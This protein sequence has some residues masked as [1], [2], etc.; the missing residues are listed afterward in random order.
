MGHRYGGLRL[1]MILVG[2]LAAVLTLGSGQ[3]GAQEP[4]P[5]DAS[6]AQVGPALGKI[7]QISE[8]MP[9]EIARGSGLDI[10]AVCGNIVVSF[11]PT[12]ASTLITSTDDEAGF[13]LYT[14]DGPIDE[15][16]AVL[17]VDRCSGDVWG[18][19]G[20]HLQ[21]S[22]VYLQP[23]VRH[24]LAW[25]QED[26]TETISINGQDLLAFVPPMFQNV[27]Y[28]YRRDSPP[29][30]SVGNCVHTVL[31]SFVADS[32]EVELWATDNEINYALYTRNSNSVFDTVDDLIEATPCAGGFDDWTRLGQGTGYHTSIATDVGQTYYLGIFT[33]DNTERLIVNPVNPLRRP[34]ERVRS[35]GEGEP[36]TLTRDDGISMEA[37][38]ACGNL[39]AS[40]VATNPEITIHSTDANAGLQIWQLREPRQGFGDDPEL[41]VDRCDPDSWASFD[42]IGNFQTVT[43]E[44]DEQ[45]WI[46][47]APTDPVATIT[48][49]RDNSLRW[50]EE[51]TQNELVA[52][53]RD[54][55]GPRATAGSCVHE[56]IGTFVADDTDFEM[57][58]IDNE[59]NFALYV[60][61]SGLLNPTGDDLTAVTDCRNDWQRL[62]TFGHYVSEVTEP[63]VRYFL[64]WYQEDFAEDLIIN[65]T[66]PLLVPAEAMPVVS[67][68]AGLGRVDVN[69]TN[70]STE[71]AEYRVK[72]QGLTDRVTTVAPGA[73]GRLSLTGRRPGGYELTVLRNDT[74]LLETELDIDCQLPNSAEPE[75]RVITSCLNGMG[76]VRFQFV[77]P[78]GEPRSW[79][80]EFDGVPN[81]ST[82]TTAYGQALRGTSGRPGGFHQARIFGPGNVLIASPTVHVNCAPF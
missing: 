72:F 75:V 48:L 30:T 69:M 7:P 60:D 12:Q 49:N 8:G 50:V 22:R 74:L 3:A 13:A 39:V 23:G 15:D 52:R 78:T 19:Y 14:V 2:T 5:G 51:L 77:N 18:D 58:S 36:V 63:G 53:Q 70:P 54:T 21:A 11:I 41:I 9:F 34:L 73:A 61:N 4:Q 32:N 45:Y 33:E 24:W 26:N 81:R 65:S 35:I 71:A 79:L 62:E 68:L 6:S 28:E 43:L 42:A 27:E 10:D 17:A 76:L 64:G 47:W 82:S 1:L 66:D 80:I 40:F 16:N 31:G 25:Y 38:N 37:E 67:C 57:W 56:I 29:E 20:H 46:T 55:L 44:P 59:Q